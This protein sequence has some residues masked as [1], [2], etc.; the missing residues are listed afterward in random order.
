MTHDDWPTRILSNVGSLFGGVAAF[1]AAVL[2]IKKLVKLHSL[3]WKKSRE[4]KAGREKALDQLLPSTDPSHLTLVDQV[5][6]NGARLANI[7]IAIEMLGIEHQASFELLGLALWHSDSEGK[8]IYI[9]PTLAELLGMSTEEARGWGWLTS[10]HTDDR[11][12]VR[13][14]YV[15]S[16]TDKRPFSEY[17]RFKRPDGTTKYV[18]GLAYPVISPSSQTQPVKFIGRALEITREEWS[19][20]LKEETP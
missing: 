18:H 7:E 16:I 11:K 8:A 9:S 15:F 4:L 2:G 12:R 3:R 5:K 17:Y 10:I 6:A 14:E 13:N 20:N 1:A 19:S